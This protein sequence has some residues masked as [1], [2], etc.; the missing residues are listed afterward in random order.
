MSLL[1]GKG[2]PGNGGPQRML[3]ENL[4]SLTASYH[5]GG[6]VFCGVW[7]CVGG[8]WYVCG[9]CVV[10]VWGTVCGTVCG[11]VCVCVWYVWCVC[12]YSVVCM[13]CV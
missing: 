4:G 2:A 1:A 10:Y 6:E 9:M 8:V 13:D 11:M 12:V 5:C 7:L 3:A